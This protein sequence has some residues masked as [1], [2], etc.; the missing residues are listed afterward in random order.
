MKNQLQRIPA[1]AGEQSSVDTAAA[2]LSFNSLPKHGSSCQQSFL[3]QFTFCN[4]D[5]AIGNILNHIH[6]MYNIFKWI[7]FCFI[8]PLSSAVYF[9]I[10]F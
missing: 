3:T 9:L 1:L 7:L 8:K 4:F 10:C 2:Y 6:L 5:F